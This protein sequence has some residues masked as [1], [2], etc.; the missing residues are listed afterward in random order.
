M[1][2]GKNMNNLIDLHTHSN[3]SDGTFSP[4]E[5]VKLASKIDLRAVAITDHDTSSGITEGLS[6]GKK[7]G[8]EVIPGIEMSID[9]KGPENGEMHILGLFIDPENDK[10]LKTSEW[11]KKKRA[12]RLP[13]MLDLLE[14]CDIQISEDEVLSHSTQGITSRPHI[15]RVM[16]KK[17]YVGSIKQA[18]DEYLKKGAVA[19]VGKER[20]A[21]EKA[22]YLILSA[23]GIPILAH[24]YSL[25]LQ[26]S[27]LKCLIS[28][29]KDLGLQGIEAYYPMH[30]T[31]DNNNYLE[32][33]S[34]FDLLLSGGTDFHGTNKPQIQL[35]MGHGNLRIPYSLLET[36]KKSLN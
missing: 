17:G 34:E 11:L 13:R 14:K 20:L 15:A 28:D 22:M 24:P 3:A 18:F 23:G 4:R 2:R 35:G 16:I 5:L 8:I 1:I 21:L 32:I 31:E 27:K 25:N 10:I 29:M 33:A 7:L 12:E 30:S 26:V 36:M 19:Y 9:Y 6:Q